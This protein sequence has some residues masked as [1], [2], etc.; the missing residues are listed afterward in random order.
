M[1][2]MNGYEAY[3]LCREARVLESLLAETNNLICAETVKRIIMGQANN[4]RLSV[5]QGYD[6][7]WFILNC[8][9]YALGFSEKPPSMMT[10][11]NW[12]VPKGA[13]AVGLDINTPSTRN[14]CGIRL[15]KRSPLTVTTGFVCK[16][17]YYLHE[18]SF[19]MNET[20]WGERYKGVTFVLSRTMKKDN[21][22]A[23]VVVTVSLDCEGIDERIFDIR[24]M[25]DPDDPQ[26][27]RKSEA[28]RLIK[29]IANRLDYIIKDAID[30]FGTK[31]T[32]Y[33]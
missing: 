11:T 12:L 29:A 5:E 15:I 24:I 8:E 18:V 32:G 3:F 19:S 2:G 9:N 27:R 23:V 25:T 1:R 30:E 20:L 26:L 4:C 22:P 6:A 16:H 28:R 10:Y 33:I 31:L 7:T 14:V 17:R 21:K 13:F